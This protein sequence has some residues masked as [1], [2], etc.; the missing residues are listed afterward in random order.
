MKKKLTVRR[1][2]AT[3]SQVR[4][5]SHYNHR[6]FLSVVLSPQVIQYFLGYLEAGT[7]HDGVNDDAGMR[8]VRGQR[9]LHLHNKLTKVFTEHSFRVITA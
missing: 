5:I 3:S 9:I 6:S 8:L 7:R 4:L 1:D 2:G